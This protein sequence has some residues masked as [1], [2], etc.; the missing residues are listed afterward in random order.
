MSTQFF[1]VIKTHIEYVKRFLGFSILY[2][3]NYL[4][5]E[6]NENTGKI[7]ILYKIWYISKNKAPIGKRG[8]RFGERA[9]TYHDQ[10]EKLK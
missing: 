8:Y 7:H 10:K 6:E 1:F 9:C 5:Y 2:L 4:C 3:D